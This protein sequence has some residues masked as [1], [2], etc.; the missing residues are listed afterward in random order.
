MSGGRDHVAQKEWAVYVAVALAAAAAVALHPAKA[1]DYQVYF[2]NTHHYFAGAA[3]YGPASG[4]GWAGGVYRYPP[5]FLDLFRG[6]AWLPLAWG[7]ALWAAGK[8]LALGALLTH[9]RRRWGLKSSAAFWPGLILIAPYFVQEVRYGNA[10]F[11]IVALCIVGLLHLRASAAV[12]LAAALKVWPLLFLPCLFF[13]RRWRALAWAAAS[14]VGLTLLPALWRG[15]GA[16]MA[17][18]GQW[19]TQERAIGKLNEIWY[20][21]QS[22]HDVLLR[23]LTV[24]DYSRL[25]DTAYRQVAWLHWSPIGVERLWWVLV[26]LLMAG[27]F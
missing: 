8:V 14:V 18:L 12:G 1:I 17:L 26:V 5:L 15:P 11:Y 20:P 13:A 7:A 9:L 21:G 25:P 16:Q 23:Y 22:L 19:L 3:M 24:V 10:Q 4:T 2:D 6:L 27:F